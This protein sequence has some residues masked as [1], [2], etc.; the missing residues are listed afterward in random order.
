MARM[1]G[2]LAGETTVDL[3]SL[4]LRLLAFE[5]RMWRAKACRRSTL[6]GRDLEALLS[7][8][9]GLQLQLDLLGLWQLYPP[10]G[11]ISSSVLQRRPSVTAVKPPRACHS[12]E[13]EATRNL[14]LVLK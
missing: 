10:I 4:L 3:P 6:A 14:A 13:P 11:I 8:S 2:A 5:V 7:A 1:A 12:E 9:V